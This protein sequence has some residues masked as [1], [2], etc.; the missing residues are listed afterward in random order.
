MPH[1][2][3]K[4]PSFCVLVITKGEVTV[5]GL[6]PKCDDLQCLGAMRLGE[7]KL[8]DVLLDGGEG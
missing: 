4:D 7:Q 5:F 6:G 1:I 8:I 2:P 3:E